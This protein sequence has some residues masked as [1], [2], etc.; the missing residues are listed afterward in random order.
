MG[1]SFCSI[2]CIYFFDTLSNILDAKNWL[3]TV[4]IFAKIGVIAWIGIDEF[5]V[6]FQFFHK[7]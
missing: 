5:S 3:K 6:A 2:T 4:I 7:N 1:K